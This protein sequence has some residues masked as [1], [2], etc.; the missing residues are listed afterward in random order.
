[1]RYPTRQSS[2]CLQLLGVLELLFQ[3]V[4]ADTFGAEIEDHTGQ[5]GEIFEARLLGGR[6]LSRSIVEGIESTD[7]LSCSGLDWVPEE[8][9]HPD[10]LQ[11]VVVG[12]FWFCGRI[13]DV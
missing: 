13:L 4:P 12:E 10:L 7:R 8:G 11:G 9:P 2:Y 6:P 3:L 5:A 1:M